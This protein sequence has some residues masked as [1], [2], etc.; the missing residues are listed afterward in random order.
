M[1][2]TRDARLNFK[3]FDGFKTV[4]ALRLFTK[5]HKDFIGMMEIL[6]S[7]CDESEDEKLSQLVDSF[8]LMI[9]SFNDY[10]DHDLCESALELLLLEAEVEEFPDEIGD[11]GLYID[12]THL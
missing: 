5:H 4:I 7:I 2:K 1:Y 11:D 8:T 12:V 9:D 6:Q 10:V 3:E